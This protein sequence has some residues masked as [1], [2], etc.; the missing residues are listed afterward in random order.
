ML[1]V[2]IIFSLLSIAAILWN[3]HSMLPP[4]VIG[5]ADAE[6]GIVVSGMPDY[7]YLLCGFTIM[8][9]IVVSVLFLRSKIR[10]GEDK[11]EKE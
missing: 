11:R 8:L 4:N 2:S 7:V 5:Y 10:N 9:L 3:K 1:F 6:T